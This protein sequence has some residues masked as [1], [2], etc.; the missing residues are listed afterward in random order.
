MS[1]S[2]RGVQQQSGATFAVFFGVELPARFH[3]VE[4]EWKAARRGCALV[5]AGFRSLLRA[6]GSERADFL[7]G[8]LTNQIKTLVPGAG[9]HAAHL[10]AQGRVVADMR[11]FALEDEIRLDVPVQRKAILRETLDRYL[12]ADDVEFV[13]GDDIRPLLGLE[14]P[15]SAEVAAKVFAAQLD[16]MPPLAHVAREVDGAALCIANASHAGGAGFVVYGGASSAASLWRRCAEA[17]AVPIGMEALDVL[18]VEA[19]IPWCDR[20]MDENVLAPEVGLESAIS[21]TKGCYIGQEVVERVAARGQV[22]RKLM[23]V[24]CDGSEPPPAGTPLLRDGDEVGVITSAV[25]SLARGRVLAL[26]YVRRSAWTAGTEVQVGTGGRGRVAPEERA[27]Q[28]GD[29]SPG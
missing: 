25:R 28:P 14:G 19:G 22:Q 10:T 27:K 8:M 2:L 18:R 24:E 16:G 23:S 12:V 20:D 3:G 5:D 29:E 1:D 13:E 17:G 7:Q 4:S 6:T 11:V 21:F 9:V 26:A 15:G